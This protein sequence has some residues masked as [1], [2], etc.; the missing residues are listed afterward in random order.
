MS[1]HEIKVSAIKPANAFFRPTVSF[2][3]EKQEVVL[4]ALDGAMSNA[5]ETANR[6]VR[7][8]IATIE[9]ISIDSVEVES[10]G[11]DQKSEKP[12]LHIYL[13]AVPGFV[14]DQADEH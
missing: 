1:I 2:L 4:S 11:R 12:R 14:D 6:L 7:Q 10:R 13:R 3:A 9:R 8:K 5:V